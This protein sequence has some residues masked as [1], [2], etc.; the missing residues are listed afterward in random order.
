MHNNVILQCFSYFLTLYRDSRIKQ[1]I[2]SLF[3]PLKRKWNESSLYHFFFLCPE[4]EKDSKLL[5][6]VLLLI[7]KIVAIVAP[8]L[9]KLLG[10]F[11]ESALTY[12]I[13]ST[14]NYFAHLFH[15]SYVGKAIYGYLELKT[16]EG[17]Q[18]IN[19]KAALYSL[20]IWG[21]LLF[22]CAMLMP[23]KYAVLLS[24]GLAFAAAVFVYPVMGV[25][26]TACGAPFL[27]TM[28]LVGIILLTF[29]AFFVRLLKQPKKPY[30]LDQ[31]G[32]AIL[33]F[34]IVML[35]SALFSFERT[36]S[37]KVVAVI[38]VFMGFYFLM[39]HLIETK[40]QLKTLVAG[41][42]FAGLGVA[43]VGIY[44][45]FF[46]VAA[47]N[48]WID[49]EM[50]SDISGRVY[51]TFENPNVFGEYLLLVIPLCFAWMLQAKHPLAKAVSG[52]NFALLCLCMIFTYSR[53]CWLGLLFS[54][55]LFAMFYSK[56]YFVLFAI[57]GVI[58][59]MFLP[60][61]IINRFTSIGNLEDSSSLYRLFIYLASFGLL[62][63]F[64]FSGIGPGTPAFNRIYPYYS[65]SAV[66]APHS[67]NLYL[68]TFIEY[69]L[70]GLISLFAICVLFFKK[71]MHT[72]KEYGEQ[73]EKIVVAALIVGLAG[74]LLQ[75]VF[76]YTFYNYRMI[77]IFY[78]YLCFGSL[79]RKF[80]IKEKNN[81]ESI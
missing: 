52:I 4:K 62:K 31:T 24:G 14:I 57:A 43:L 71:A 36:E 5:R 34:S 25:F 16:P 53:G 79:Y 27:P 40:T 2:D 46:G 30:Q 75:S 37:L 54:V 17:Y 33:V 29:L 28:A 8:R 15:E 66:I 9:R 67:H 41:F 48:V 26:L 47:G 58:G 51:S 20:G 32:I 65:Y 76:D 68:Q 64:W 73:K 80:L 70:T 56:H 18:S 72:F 78:T 60:E 21:L 3:A 55:V 81:A 12:G 50:F 1:L 74:F 23:L 22:S 42:L 59:V 38:L 77:L 7:H 6:N 44:Q 39:Y 69:G 49:Q 35:L 63:Q 13:R 45:N 61:S 19:K 10:L 11:S